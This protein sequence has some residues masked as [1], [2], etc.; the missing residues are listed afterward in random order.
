MTSRKRASL[1]RCEV[2]NEQQVGDDTTMNFLLSNVDTNHDDNFNA[3]DMANNHP[4]DAYKWEGIVI[5]PPPTPPPLSTQPLMFKTDQK[6]TVAL[7]KLLD[8][9]NAPDYAFTKLLKL[10]YCAQAEGYSFHPA[11][12]GLLSLTQNID[13][14]FASLK[15]AKQ[16][17]PSVSTVFW[18]DFE[19]NSASIVI[20]F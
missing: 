10:A 14:L 4:S 1:L 19:F 11:N 12:G 18:F 2:I 7:L 8:N 13:V 9:T 15:S 6:W 20:I 16:L 17:L 5:P 3:L